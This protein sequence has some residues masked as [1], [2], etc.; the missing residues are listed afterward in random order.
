MATLHSIL[1]EIATPS[2]VKFSISLIL[3]NK[4]DFL[5]HFQ[6]PRVA[7]LPK[8]AQ[9][10]EALFSAI[11]G[12]YW[13]P[14]DKLPTEI[15][16]ADATPY[17]LGTVQKALRALVDEGLV[18]RRQGHGTFVAEGRKS[19]DEPWHLRFLG[20]NRNKFLPLFPRVILRQRIS[21]QGPWTA[22]LEQRGDNII[23][24]DRIISVNGEFNVYSKFFANADKF[25]NLLEMPLQELDTENFKAYLCRQFNLAITGF[26]QT[27]ALISLPDA[28]CKAI[29]VKMQAPGLRMEVVAYAGRSNP[30][31]Y[32]ELF[33]P[34]NAHQLLVSDSYEAK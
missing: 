21:E 33:I 27:L 29:G 28:I 26:S 24:I 19:M 15:E 8:Y 9:L 14:G 20:S 31:Y 16:L 1:N 17:S 10:R 34:E 2:Q 25:G 5:E 23:R 32:Q 6:Q 4:L 18:I 13:K 30:I 22:R 3:M 11:K 12:G 7:G